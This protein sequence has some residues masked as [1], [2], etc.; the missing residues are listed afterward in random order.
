MSNPGTT[1]TTAPP[2]TNDST[3]LARFGYQQE[4]QRSLGSFS[5][6]AAGFSY[7]SIMTGVFQL[8]GFGFASGGPAFVWTWPLVFIGQG[9]VALCFAEMAGQFPLAGGV[10]QWSKQIARPVAS[11]MAGWI[12]TIGAIVTAAAVAVAYQVIL[13]QVSLAFQV[14]GGAADAGVTTTPNGAQNAIVLALGLVVFTTIVNIVGVRLM[15]KINNLGV[16]VELIGVTLLIIMLAV[17]IKRGPQVVLHTAGTGA[18][19]SWGYLGAFLVASIMSAYVFYGFDTAGM[20]AEET[21]EP[22]RHAP[23][24]IL[25]AVTAAFLAGGLLML[26]GMMAVGNINASELGTL[27]MPYLVKSTL[28]TGLG[29]AFLICSAIAITVCCL[30]VQTAAIRLLFSMARDGRL[31]FGAALAKVSPRSSTPVAPAVVTGV[32]TIALLLVNIGNQ[33]VFYILTSVAIILFYLPYLLVTAPMLLRRLRGRWPRADHGPYFSL[34]RWGLVVN[35]VA[36]GYGVAMTVNLA[37]PRAAVYGDD[38][39][40]YTW[41]AIVFTAVVS[42]VGGLLYLRYGSRGGTPQHTAAEPVTN[43]GLATEA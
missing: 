26:V 8:F 39:W 27:G 12:M 24:A 9:A 20:L 7:I 38:H 31:P 42:A 23:R 18:G 10:Y 15:A 25:R 40:Y 32:L 37:W 13:P 2:P 41:G 28:G 1:R 16:A 21:T 14:V 17:H 34:G 11:W 22:R 36:V 35:I 5:S 43:D 33:R 19:H 29:D 3:D 6:F 30:A 4:L